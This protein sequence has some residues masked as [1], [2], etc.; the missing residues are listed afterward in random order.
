MKLYLKKFKIIYISSWLLSFLA[1][2]ILFF[3]K[4]FH[5]YL[6]F[7][8]NAYF[9]SFV[10]VRI[11]YEC[12]LR[13]RKITNQKF[14]RDALGLELRSHRIFYSLWLTIPNAIIYSLILRN[15][16]VA[17]YLVW[18]LFV[19]LTIWLL[20]SPWYSTEQETVQNEQEEKTS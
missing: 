17:M 3:Y 8:A 14:F 1:I 18:F 6:G 20:K 16:S 12:L 4:D 7:F 2:F 5:R 11:Q 13:K 9:L 19:I 10:G 15:H